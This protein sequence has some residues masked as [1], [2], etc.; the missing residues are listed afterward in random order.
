MIRR[1]LMRIFPKLLD[2]GFVLGL[3]G[4]VGVATFAGLANPKGDGFAFIP[5]FMTLFFGLSGMVVSFGSLY[6]LLDIRD[7][8]R[9]QAQRNRNSGDTES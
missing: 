5:F 8:V 2:V 7:A 3:I 4:A 6:L 1:W 9:G